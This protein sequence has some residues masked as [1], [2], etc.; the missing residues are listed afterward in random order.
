MLPLIEP[1]GSDVLRLMKEYNVK[2]KA[3]IHKLEPLVTKSYLMKPRAPWFNALHLEKRLRV[4]RL[5][6]KFRRTGQFVVRDIFKMVRNSYRDNI[7]RASEVYQREQI[8]TVDHK[9]MFRMI[10]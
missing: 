6:I 4:R 1:L 8:E 9:T 10:D 5:E 3:V 7:S 2:M